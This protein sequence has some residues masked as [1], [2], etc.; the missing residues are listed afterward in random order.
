MIAHFES[1]V[2]D[3]TSGGY[4]SLVRRSDFARSNK[5]V[6][7]RAATKVVEEEVEA[8]DVVKDHY[9]VGGLKFT[10]CVVT[11]AGGVRYYA[12]RVVIAA[13]AGEHAAPPEV[14]ALAGNPRVMNMDVFANKVGDLAGTGG[15][16][17]LMGPNAGIDTVETAL[18]NGFRVVWLIRGDA[19]PVLLGTNHQKYARNQTYVNYQ[20]DSL[21]V[22]ATANQIKVTCKTTAG[23]DVSEVGNYFVYAIGQALSKNVERIVAALKSRL[24]PVFDSDQRF[25]DVHESV[26]GFQVEGSNRS[27]G[28]QM[29]GALALQVSKSV[30]VGVAQQAYLRRMAD[31]IFD[32]QNKLVFGYARLMN[33]AVAADARALVHPPEYVAQNYTAA[34]VTAARDRLLRQLVGLDKTWA[35]RVTALAAMLANCCTAADFFRK[36]AGKHNNN[37][38]AFWGEMLARPAAQ[39]TSSVVQSPQLGNIRSQMVSLNSFVPAYVADDVNFSHDDRTVL[40]IYVALNYPLVSEEV[41]QELIGQV[42]AGRKDA[43]GGWGYPP[44]AVA[45]FKTRL[46]VRNEY[47]RAVLAQAK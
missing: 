27:T 14:K 7:D 3:Y 44:L 22:S 4:G 28:I 41:A 47:A 26:L 1:M 20:G 40:R 35:D 42:I 38:T 39:L 29:V 24:E 10:G 17:F 9:V 13:G 45:T 16:V 12:K 5:K 43:G 33:A 23:K 2:P 11:T 46:Q 15:T 36:R 30:D 32:V 21:K 31:A 34:E 8:V 6:I 19:K 18:F 37:P 25:G